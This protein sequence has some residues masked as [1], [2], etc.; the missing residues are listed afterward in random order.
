M[1]L[2][3]ICIPSYK[4]EFFELCLGS[5]IAQS[6]TDTEIIV[7]DDCPTDAIREI[8][9]KYPGRIN[10][11]RNDNPGG[12]NNVLRLIGLANGE[13]IKFLFDDD[14]LH[15]FC[16]QYLLEA[17]EATKAQSTTLAYSPRDFIDSR[18][19]ITGH[20]NLLKI[21]S[22]LKVLPGAGCINLMASNSLNF[23]GEFTTT[24]FRRGDCFAADGSIDLLDFDD[25]PSRGLVDVAAWLN[26]AAKGNIVAHP[27]TLSYFRRH[28][29]SNSNPSMN[30]E[31]IYG[32]TEWELIVQR[33][34]AAG[35][36]DGD[37]MIRAY[38]AL[39]KNY[40]Y[41][42][43]VFPNLQKDVERFQREL[44]AMGAS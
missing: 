33:A 36:M 13:Y 30:S 3:S 2:V 31:F 6:Y 37:S 5:A 25:T 24:M 11:S 4:P 41:W 26:L 38:R 9:D 29:A 18:N 20:V 27:M 8:C 44:A 10:Y 19:N 22:E 40:T 17:L 15:P 34:K 39:I 14:V 28:D 21:E 42:I 12:R 1:P 23:I 35:L 16:V 32:I 43:N 7:S